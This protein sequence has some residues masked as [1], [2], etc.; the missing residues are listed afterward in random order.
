MYWL[1]LVLGV[2]LLFF[3][4]RGLTRGIVREV[5][6]ISAVFITLVLTGRYGTALGRKIVITLG[7]DPDLA[8]L[9]GFIAI[10]VGV[11][12]LAVAVNY[13]WSHLGSVTPLSFFDKLGG[14]VF[15][16]A[17]AGILILIFLVVLT[18]LPIENSDQ[19]ITRSR[20]AYSFLKALPI[21][22]Q[23]L[24]PIWPANWPQLFI[25][26]DGW[27]LQEGGAQVTAGGEVQNEK[28]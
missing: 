18:S 22:Y 27:W 4:L 9:L 3:L 11:A 26:P 6:D 20:L 21:V 10:A 8:A 28:L 19:I 17:K 16:L 12:V 7:W 14:A 15:G 13:L 24:A 25:T 2:L 5:V 1:D 23:V